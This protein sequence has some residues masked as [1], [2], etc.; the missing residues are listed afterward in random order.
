MKIDNGYNKL[1]F[2][3]LI[4]LSTILMLYI[5]HKYHLNNN[6]YFTKPMIYIILHIK[7]AN[8]KFAPKL[9]K[10]CLVM[11]NNKGVWSAIYLDKTSIFGG[12][13]NIEDNNWIILKSSDNKTII[14]LRLNPNDNTFIQYLKNNG[15]NDN[16]NGDFTISYEKPDFTKI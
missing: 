3:I 2:A 4:I 11:L 16:A 6:I 8:G 10:K 13:Y 15:E 12:Y 7:D 9:N 5:H 1:L 14:S